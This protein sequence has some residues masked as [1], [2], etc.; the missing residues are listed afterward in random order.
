[1]LDKFLSTLNP[2]QAAKARQCLEMFVKHNGGDIYRRHVLIE[3]KLTAGAKVELRRNGER[4]LMNPNGSWLDRANITKTGLD[5][6]EFISK[7]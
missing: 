5:Y 7:L 4:V 3:T 2:M 1:M 6:A